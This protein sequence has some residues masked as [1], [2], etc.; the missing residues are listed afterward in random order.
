MVFKRYEENA[1]QINNNKFLVIFAAIPF[2]LEQ[3]GPIFSSFNP[4]PSLP[5]AGLKI[6]DSRP[7]PV[8]MTGQIFFSPDKPQFWPVE[9]L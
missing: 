6:T 4:C 7:S 9:I 1:R 3:V 2:K 5:F 8:L